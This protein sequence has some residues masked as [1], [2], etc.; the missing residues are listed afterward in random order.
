MML[1]AYFEIR[2]ILYLAGIPIVCLLGWLVASALGRPV[3]L[4][5]GL[6]IWAIYS[7]LFLFFF[8]G[9][10]IG[11]ESQAS[12]DMR[13]TIAESPSMGQK[14]AEVILTF[15]DYPD[16]QVGEFS[17][18]LANYLRQ[19]ADQVLP[20]TFTITRD[21]GRMRGFRLA[22]VGDFTGWQS[23]FGYSAS[24]GSGLPSPW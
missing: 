4:R 9:P 21:Y 10:F 5:Y 2:P 13:W 8:H 11:R 17:D 15:V 7:G 19:R 18:Q 6:A 16:H 1:V 14:Q 24:S 20:V 22:Q 23:S 12:F 3:R